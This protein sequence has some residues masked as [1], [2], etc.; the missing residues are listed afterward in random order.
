MN[1]LEQR[2]VPGICAADAHARVRLAFGKDW[3]FPG[4][5]PSFKVAREHV[6]LPPGAGGGNPCRA[7]AEIL[8]ALRKG[9]SYCGLDSLYPADGFS[10]RVSQ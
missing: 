5:V 4:Y 2:P 3:R 8:D 1:C 7:S 9:H 6:L 10:F